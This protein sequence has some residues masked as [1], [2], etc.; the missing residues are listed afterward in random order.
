MLIQRVRAAR[1]RELPATFLLLLCLTGLG[2][3]VPTPAQAQPDSV[4][5]ALLQ[6]RDLPPDHTPRRALWRAAA[7]PGWGQ[8]YNRQ[9]LKLPFV[10]AGLAGLT[11]AVYSYNDRYLL[12]RHAHLFKIEQEQTP[13]E[14]N[15]FAEFEEEY[16]SIVAEVGGDL[17]ARQLR[18]ER[19]RL[20]RWRDLS[21]VGTGVFYA[22]TLV[23]AYVSAHLLTFDVG[24]NLALRVRPQGPFPVPSQLAP[25]RGMGVHMTLQLQ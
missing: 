9:Y 8:V 12:Y 22:L 20:R 21:I 11:Y 24:D 3:A 16:N 18:S 19:D 4:R 13:D 7:V 15:P 10:Y 5:A 6:A 23:D 14:P 2:F 17:E 1:H 25:S